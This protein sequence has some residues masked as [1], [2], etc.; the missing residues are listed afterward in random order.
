MDFLDEMRAET[1]ALREQVLGHPFVR[2]I[3]DG[4]LDAGRFRFYLGQD[5]AFLIEYARIVAIASAK[6]PDLATQARFASLLDATLNV[7]M[8]LHRRVCAANGIGPDE[9]VATQPTLACAAY[10]Q[11]L[12]SVAWTGTLGELCASLVPCQHGYAEI[13]SSLAPATRPDNSYADWIVAYAS[14]EYQELAEWICDLTDRLASEA[15]E[16]EREAM[17]RAYVDSSVHELAF[18]DMAWAAF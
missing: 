18:W 7:E 10:T 1:K 5:Y 11:H 17:R 14:P 15:T 8:D 16:P 13:A 9:L 12:L 2:G 3:G 6:S 4:T